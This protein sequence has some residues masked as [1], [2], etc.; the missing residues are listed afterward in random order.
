MEV[1]AILGAG[2]NPGGASRKKAPARK[3]GA[4]LPAVLV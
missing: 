4:W 1:A 2:A 3:S